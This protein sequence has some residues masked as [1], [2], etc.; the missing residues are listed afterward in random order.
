MLA[1][2]SAQAGAGAGALFARLD[3]D[4]APSAGQRPVALPD[5]RRA[6]AERLL[7]RWAERIRS[8]EWNDAIGELVLMAQT[9]E[10]AYPPRPN[11]K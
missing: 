4:G 7:L 1:R 9:I 11:A 3:A 8:G 10:R 6:E 2:A 5:R